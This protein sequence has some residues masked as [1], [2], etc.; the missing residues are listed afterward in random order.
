[1]DVFEEFPFGVHSTVCSVQNCWASARYILYK[2][3]P[4]DPQ[5]INIDV[6]K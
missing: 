4:V 6:E 1:M 3:A 5:N 2:D